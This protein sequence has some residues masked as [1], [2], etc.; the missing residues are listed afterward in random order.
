MVEYVTVL[1]MEY[2]MDDARDMWFALGEIFGMN[3]SIGCW[4]LIPDENK[5]ATVALLCPCTECD[6]Y[7]AA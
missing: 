6:L 4:N 5:G 3:S 2:T 7:N 1:G